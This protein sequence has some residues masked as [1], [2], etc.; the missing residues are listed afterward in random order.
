[1]DL[2]HILN[3]VAEGTMTVAEAESRIRQGDIKSSRGPKPLRL[4]GLTFIAFGALFAAIGGGMGF[5]TWAAADG[6][7]TTAGT[8][9]R[10]TGGRSV[11]PVVQYQVGGRTIEMVGGVATSPPAYEIG[12]K[13]TVLYPPDHPENG[14][15]DTFVE[16]RLFPTVFGG[17]GTAF[18]LVGTVAT[19]AGYTRRIAK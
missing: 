1:M 16:R 4:V 10:L 15:I 6:A 17:V 3:R 7:L 11:K 13:V 5:W 2:K 18:L 9:V 19:I 14:L 8:V 12:E